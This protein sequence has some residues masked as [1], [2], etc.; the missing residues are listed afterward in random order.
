MENSSTIESLVVGLV[1]VCV[2]GVQGLAESNHE[3]PASTPAI[4]ADASGIQLS[5][6]AVNLIVQVASE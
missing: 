2:F 3:A 4:A 6:G 1:F 5:V